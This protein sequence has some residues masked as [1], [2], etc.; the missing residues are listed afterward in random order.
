VLLDTRRMW[1]P[2]LD[3]SYELVD[4]RT[5]HLR[6]MRILSRRVVT[7]YTLLDR[8]MP[9]MH[10][11]VRPS[12]FVVLEGEARFEERGRQEFLARGGVVESDALRGGTEA[13][14]GT[15]SS[16]LALEWDPDVHGAGFE[17]PFAVGRLARSDLLGLAR[18]AIRLSEPDPSAAS[19][20]MIAIL[21]AAGI[22]F[23]RA[24]PRAWSEEAESLQPL[25]AVVSKRLAA[26]DER[27]AI[28]EV[29]AALR[30]N[31]RR[32]HRG[33]GELAKTYGFSWR[34]WREALH[35]ARLLHALRLLAVPGATTELV[36]RLTGFRAPAALCHAFVKARLPSPGRLAHAADAEILGKWSEIAARMPL[37]PASAKSNGPAQSAG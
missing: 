16:C 6:I 30:W 28:E 32:I 29:Q 25:Q 11:K 36:A 26:L 9:Y 4:V 17:G 34:N 18:A 35:Q 13:H 31:P 3:A 5:R 15:P 20:E 23:H 8:A 2:A 22:P 7:D 19:A 1:A 14:G 12:L 10:R 37:S 21:R 24:D 33:M 27:P